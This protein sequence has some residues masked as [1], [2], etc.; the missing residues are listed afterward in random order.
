MGC[1]KRKVHGAYPLSLRMP[2]IVLSLGRTFY[3]FG[4]PL[5]DRLILQPWVSRY[6]RNPLWWGGSQ[7]HQDT[8]G[9]RLSLALP[10]FPSEINFDE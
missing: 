1:G 3:N 4:T 2:L 7:V 8:H 5:A 9:W 10:L 6:A